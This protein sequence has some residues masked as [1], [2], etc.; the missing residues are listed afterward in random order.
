LRVDIDPQSNAH[1]W[2]A[3]LRLSDRFDLTHHDAACLA[4][5]LRLRAP[6][7][8]LDEALRPAPAALEAPLLRVDA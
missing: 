4:L 2:T 1:A 5:A 8:T 3:T 7:A 6:L